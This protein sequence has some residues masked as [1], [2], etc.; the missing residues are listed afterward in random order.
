M[1]NI[2]LKIIFFFIFIAQISFT[3]AQEEKTV[4]AID[5]DSVS[6]SDDDKDNEFK[7]YLQNGN[8]TLQNGKKS[9]TNDNYLR[10]GFD[11]SNTAI[12]ISAGAYCDDI[13]AEKVPIDN[14]TFNAEYD[15]DF[16]DH[17]S[18]SINYAY[19]DYYS[20]RQVSS[21]ENNVFT[22]DGS[23]DNKIIT[24]DLSL[25]YSTGKT[26]DYTVNFDASHVFSFKNINTKNDRLM[27][28][29]IVGT[30]MGTTN[31]YKEYINKN[32]IRNKKGE[33]IKPT[34]IN[35]QFQ[36]TSIYLT[37]AIA[38]RIGHFSISGGIT[39]SFEYNEPK[40]TSPSNTPVYYIKTA[41]YF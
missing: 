41:V 31:F 36:L 1:R 37:T 28:P 35:T 26:S 8:C 9:A 30:Y 4:K 11:Y 34:D 6:T 39:Y 21:S 15:K 12:G 7:A 24:P 33:L 22:L 38:Y 3:Y 2:H 29:I 27:I 19:G 20:T 5:K 23:W 25:I 18:T 40:G 16:G 10:S 32:K 13:F 17:F 14:I